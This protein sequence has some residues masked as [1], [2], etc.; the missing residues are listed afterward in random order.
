MSR[1]GDYVKLNRSI[2]DWEWWSD[3]NT[4]RVFTYMLLKANWK[5]TNYKGTTVP[6]GSFVSSLSRLSDATNLTID[7]VRTALKHL[8]STG[9]ITS[10]SH[11]RSTI[12]T[13]NNYNVYQDNPEQL[14]KEVPSDSHSIPT[15]LPIVK[16]KK[17]GKNIKNIY[18]ARGNCFNDFPQADYDIGNLE[19]QLV[20][21]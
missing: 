15:L 16:E 12:F 5:D 6:R 9:E 2:L 7:E 14:T 10:T 11:G 21:N 4:Y 20:S 17:E 13:V 1:Q 8:R 3:I 18:R 19:K